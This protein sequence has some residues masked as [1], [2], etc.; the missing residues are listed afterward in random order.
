[1]FAIF[2]DFLAT[3]LIAQFDNLSFALAALTRSKTLVL[4]EDGT[5][6]EDVTITTYGNT[7]YTGPNGAD[8]TLEDDATLFRLGG[9]GQATIQTADADSRV[10]GNDARN[11][12]V[13]N[14]AR[15]IFYGGS[16]ADQMDGGAG[17]DVLFGGAGDDRRLR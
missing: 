12:F 3:R 14:N 13:G 16:S 8:V 2:R 17:N 15:D 9:D 10:Y 7:L 5:V 1:V 4:P 6:R 11:V